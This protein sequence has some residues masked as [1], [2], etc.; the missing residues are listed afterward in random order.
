[1]EFSNQ[2]SVE[3]FAVSRTAVLQHFIYLFIL[4]IL[5]LFKGFG[6]IP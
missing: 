3:S 6:T 2:I 4:F 1:M 5:M